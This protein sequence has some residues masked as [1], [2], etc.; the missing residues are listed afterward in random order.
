M[1]KTDRHPEARLRRFIRE[2]LVESG[3]KDVPGSVAAAMP[4]NWDPHKGQR[5]EEA[6][7]SA[8]RRKAAK[9]RTSLTPEEQAS[10]DA[11]KQF[12][13][14]SG[15]QF[16]FMY[17]DPDEPAVYTAAAYDAQSMGMGAYFLADQEATSQGPS[18]GLYFNST[19]G[20]VRITPAALA[21]RTWRG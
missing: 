9:R 10:I 12:A 16:Q 6:K 1:A 20:F 4:H 7:K 17:M 15:L 5:E 21:K 11:V 13:K 14:K 3:E 19:R 18:V 8:L 2:M